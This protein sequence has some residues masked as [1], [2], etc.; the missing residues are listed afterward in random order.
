MYAAHS[1][2]SSTYD[3]G[4]DALNEF[5]ALPHSASGQILRIYPTY[6]E[7]AGLWPDKAITF[8]ENHDTEE[9]RRGQYLSPFPGGEQMLQGYAYLLTHPGLPCVFWRDIYDTDDFY[10][11][12]INDLIRIRKAYGIHSKSKLF[13]TTAEYGNAYGA[14]IQGD[15]G[16]LAMKIGPGPWQPYGDKW[17]PASQLL[18]SGADYAVWGDRGRFW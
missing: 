1:S 9:A 2:L 14:Y 13:I 5:K 7:R 16:E 18:R 17:N 15:K 6:L 8:L 12:S 11:E 10:R 3:E 4:I